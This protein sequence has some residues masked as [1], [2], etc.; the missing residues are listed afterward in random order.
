MHHPTA[1]NAEHDRRLTAKP[2]HIGFDPRC[3]CVHIDA[4]FPCGVIDG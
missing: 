1:P 2:A 3:I 4:N